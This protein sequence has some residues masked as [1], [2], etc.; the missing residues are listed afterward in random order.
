[1]QACF[2][3]GWPSYSGMDFIYGQTHLCLC[4]Q[5]QL[6]R[7]LKPLCYWNKIATFMRTSCAEINPHLLMCAKGSRGAVNVKG[8]FSESGNLGLL[9]SFKIQSLAITI[10]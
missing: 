5:M 4:D 9:L 1:M 2:Y 10:F 7:M 3:I 6:P 8:A